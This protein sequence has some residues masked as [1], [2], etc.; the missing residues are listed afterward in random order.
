MA[1]SAMFPPTRRRW[2]VVALAVVAVVAAIA[3]A[4]LWLA[5]DDPPLDPLEPVPAGSLL[6]VPPSGPVIVIMLENKNERSILDATDAPYLQSLFDTGAVATEYQAVAH[7]SE[8]N[9]LALFSGSTQGVTDNG[10]HDLNAP[11]IADQLENAGKTWGVFAENLPAVE[12]FTGETSSGGPDGDGDYARKHEPAISFTAISGS[13]QRCAN[14][15]PLR[16]FR[17]DA[18]DFSWIIPNLCHDMHDC[19]VAEG[20]AWLASVVQPILAS[21]A[22]A[23]GGS[24]TLYITFDES[25]GKAADNEIVTTVLGPKV[26]AGTRSDVAHSHYSLLRTIETSLGLPCL[27]QACEANTLGELFQP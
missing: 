15:K 23:P 16:D 1:T 27:A 22:F 7:P 2:L 6:A 3:G 5:A 11:T 8:P 14:I 21:P 12:C 24:G 20:D 19:S 17:P 9:Y 13:P 10:S 26:K 18:A 25:D 4:R